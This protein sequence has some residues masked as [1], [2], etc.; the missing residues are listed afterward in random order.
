MFQKYQCHERQK[1]KKKKM[2]RQIDLDK[3]PETFYGRP[4]RNTI[5]C[6]DR[7]KI[8]VKQNKSLILKPVELQWKLD[9]QNCGFCNINIKAVAGKE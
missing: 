4:K 6:S 9:S 2:K 8:S 3:R 5:F 1:E 7:V